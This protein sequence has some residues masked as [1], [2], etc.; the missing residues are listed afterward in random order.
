MNAID[1]QFEELNEDLDISFSAEVEIPKGYDESKNALKTVANSYGGEITDETPFRDYAPIFEEIIEERAE[2]VTAELEKTKEELTETLGLLSATE[3]ELT[4]TENELT[5]T[6]A[7]LETTRGELAETEAELEETKE[8]IPVAYENGRKDELKEFWKAIQSNGTRTDYTN[9]FSNTRLTKDSFKPVYDFKPVNASSMFY[10]CTTPLSEAF[11]MIEV[12]NECGIVFDFSN[13][14]NFQL[15][16]NASCFNELSTIDLS[17]ATSTYQAFYN[18]SSALDIKRINRLIC[19]ADTVYS[20][21]MFGYCVELEYVGF[22]GVIAKSGLDIHW[23]VLLN[24]ESLEK[25]VNCLSSETSGLTVTVSLQAVNKAFET[26][27]GANDGSN[28]QEWKD[29]IAT[30]SNWTISLS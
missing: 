9:A 22:E 19:S 28:S 27:E 2:T 7:T 4:A 12:E 13:C 24:K 1:I 20:W 3:N 30:R 29:L 8:Q 11:S 10:M 25:L 14:T 26:S 16:F 21:G 15:A 23:S 6:K 18:G 17:K 5:E